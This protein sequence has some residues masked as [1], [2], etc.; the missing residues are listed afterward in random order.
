ML[1]FDLKVEH[2][3]LVTPRLD[4]FDAGAIRV[5]H[6]QFDEAKQILRIATV[7]EAKSIAAVCGEIR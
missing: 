5:G 3:P 1:Q 2:A 7:A 4:F 6:A